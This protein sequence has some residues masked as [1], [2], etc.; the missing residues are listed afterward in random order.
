MQQ[1][2]FDALVE[3]QLAQAA[4]LGLGERCQS[5]ADDHAGFETGSWAS[6]TGWG[7][8]AATFMLRVIIN[9][10]PGTLVG[11]VRAAHTTG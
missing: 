11:D 9:N 4:R 1:F 10:L 7:I 3:P 5:T 2:D 6:R 8:A